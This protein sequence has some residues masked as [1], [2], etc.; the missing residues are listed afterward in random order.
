VFLNN[1]NII[2]NKDNELG[3]LDIGNK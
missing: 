2:G 3:D 1:N